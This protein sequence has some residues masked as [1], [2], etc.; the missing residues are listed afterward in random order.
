MLELMYLFIF[1]C[2]VFSVGALVYSVFNIR[3]A[4]RILKEIIEK[5]IVK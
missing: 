1:V 4:T 2:M 3:A 5:R